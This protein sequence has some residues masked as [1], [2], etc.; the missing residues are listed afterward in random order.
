[1]SLSRAILVTT[2]WFLSYETLHKLPCKQPVNFSNTTWLIY[3]TLIFNIIL[4]PSSLPRI[5]R[6]AKLKGSTEALSRNLLQPT[7]L[8]TSLQGSLQ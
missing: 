2:L 3:A 8:L 6:E 4:Q 7:I 1:M 5:I